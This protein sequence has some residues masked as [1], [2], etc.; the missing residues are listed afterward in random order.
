MEDNKSSVMKL[1]KLTKRKVIQPYLAQYYCN[2]RK[3]SKNNDNNQNTRRI[4]T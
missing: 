4:V 2:N 3:E 1:A